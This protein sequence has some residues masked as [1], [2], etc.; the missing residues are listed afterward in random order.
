MRWPEPPQTPNRLFLTEGLA[1]GALVNGGVALVGTD[2]DALQRAVVSF[3]A[4]MGALMDGALDA[5][6]G[7][8][9]HIVILLFL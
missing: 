1:V 9:V 7:I 3:I 8:A 2:Q 4:V 5:L 6:V